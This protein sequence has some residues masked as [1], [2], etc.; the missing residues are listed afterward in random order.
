MCAFSESAQGLTPKILKEISMQKVDI[1]TW[2]KM[3]KAYRV[4]VNGVP[5]VR[6]IED[7]NHCV[8]DAVTIEAHDTQVSTSF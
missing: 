7:S 3:N 8:W 5:F 2:R 6:V 4:W 1:D